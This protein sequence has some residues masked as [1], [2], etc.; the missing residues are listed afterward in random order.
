MCPSAIP[1][2]AGR[3]FGDGHFTSYDG[4]ELTFT[5]VGDYFYMTSETIDVD[6]RQGHPVNWQ[7]QPSVGAVLVAVAIRFSTTTLQVSLSDDK[8]GWCIFTKRKKE[9][10]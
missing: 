3:V 10:R 4:S 1:F 6:I 8:Q 7:G 5:G 9:K 2:C